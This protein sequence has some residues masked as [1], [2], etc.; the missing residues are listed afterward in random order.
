MKEFLWKTV[1]VSLSV[2]CSEKIFKAVSLV[3]PKL[4]ALIDNYLDPGEDLKR[5]FLSV[6]VG[7]I[8][9]HIL[10]RRLIR[11]LLIY[12]GAFT[13]PKSVLTKLWGLMMKLCVYENPSTHEYEYLLPRLSVPS[14]KA[15]LKQISKSVRPTIKHNSGE[16]RLRKFDKALE[17]FQKESWKAQLLLHFRSWTKTSSWLTDLWQDYAYL[18]SRDSLCR[19]SN[20]YAA[21]SMFHGTSSQA[22]RAANMIYWSN[23]FYDDLENETFDP[24]V[25]GG[26]IPASMKIFEMWSATRVPGK[27]KD[28]LNSTLASKHVT[29]LYAGRIFILEP[30]SYGRLACPSVIKAKLDSILRKPEKSPSFSI[31]SLTSLKRATWYELRKNLPKKELK[32]IESSR[33]CVV[34]DQKAIIGDADEHKAGQWGGQCG[35]IWYDKSVNINVHKNARVTFNCEHSVGE[36]TMFGM[37]DVFIMGRESYDSKGNCLDI[38]DAGKTVECY[39]LNLP[40]PDENCRAAVAKLE[41][42]KDYSIFEYNFK[43]FDEKL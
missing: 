42:M 4:I 35:N 21:D 20:Y 43:S 30:Y 34:L 39:E 24:I 29:V 40:K 32:L 25:L 15:T 36:A 8:S 16:E 9:S 23:K 17:K 5:L 26:I 12:R 27:E 10:R 41:E 11:L 2:L 14:V 19:T 3:S 28:K 1:P 37:F 13:K 6:S 38:K 22:D 31:A 18:S 7:L 33:F